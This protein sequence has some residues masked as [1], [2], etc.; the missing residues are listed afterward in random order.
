MY[1]SSTI[2]IHMVLL[3]ELECKAFLQHCLH[4]GE[5]GKRGTADSVKRHRRSPRVCWRR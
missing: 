2:K 5:V 1:L 3:I 4:G